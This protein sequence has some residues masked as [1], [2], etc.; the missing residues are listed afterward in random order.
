[1]LLLVVQGGL[2]G[3]AEHLYH[4]LNRWYSNSFHHV[5]LFLVSGGKRRRETIHRPCS[6]NS[7]DLTAG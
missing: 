7:E 5:K 4:C 2:L 3:C 1:M 6:Y